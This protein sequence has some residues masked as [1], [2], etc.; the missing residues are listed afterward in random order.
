MFVIA[1][2]EVFLFSPTSCLALSLS[3]LS[4]SLSLPLSS[5][6][7][8]SSDIILPLRLKFLFS[9]QILPFS[10]HF[11]SRS[12]LILLSF[13]SS[14]PRLHFL[15]RF[16]LDD[17]HWGILS[18]L[19]SS[20]L[21]TFTMANCSTTPGMRNHAVSHEYRSIDRSVIIVHRI[22]CAFYSCGGSLR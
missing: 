4:L 10:F 13:R 5:V 3:L 19:P 7:H 14:R 6:L 16:N 18:T 15:R 9:R 17:P 12:V 1:V 22:L 20:L 2:S 8:V 11:L 21:F